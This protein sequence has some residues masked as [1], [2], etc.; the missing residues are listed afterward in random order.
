MA[1]RRSPAGDA[2]TELVLKVFRLNGRFLDAADDITAGTGL[3]AAR[4]GVL[5]AVL[6]QP[7][8]VA[9]IARSMGLTRQSVQRLADA[10]VEEGLCAYQDNP[11]HLRAKLLAPTQRGRAAIDRVCPI[12]QAWAN[13]VGAAVGD[14]ALRAAIATVDA[15]LAALAAPTASLSQPIFPRP[16]RRARPR[17]RS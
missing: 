14:E 13:R 7:L 2:L 16:S 10:L 4:W 17:S 9:G 12:Q 8:S 3:T 11:A 5:G 6:R 15:V 1:P